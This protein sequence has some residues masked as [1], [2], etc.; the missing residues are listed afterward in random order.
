MTLFDKIVAGDIPC[1]KIYEDDV[2]RIISV[3]CGAA[4]AFLMNTCRFSA[5]PS[6]TSPL[7]LQPTS[8][9]SPRTAMA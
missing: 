7:W 3:G 5:S 2:V 4:G 6:T 1:D 9:S 8:W